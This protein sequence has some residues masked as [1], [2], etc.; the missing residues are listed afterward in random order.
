[1][2]DIDLMRVSPRLSQSRCFRSAPGHT[3]SRHC[4]LR[5]NLEGR[6]SRSYLPPD[7]SGADDEITM[8]EN[9]NAYQRI[10]FRPR[11]LRDVTN[12]DF[13][14]TILGHKVSLSRM[15]DEWMLISRR[16]LTSF[17]ADLS[18]YACYLCI[19]AALYRLT[20]DRLQLYISRRLRS[21]SWVTRTAR[22]T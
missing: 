2:L 13:A 9:R 5:L 8:R 11:I 18:P 19:R 15:R 16:S 10:W 4:G 1:M 14:S 20:F 7:S 12:I 3:V 22:R 6:S 17:L 21:A